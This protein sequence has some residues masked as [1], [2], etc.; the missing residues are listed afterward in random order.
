MAN[1]KQTTTKK[2]KRKK[3]IKQVAA[4]VVAAAG[5]A[6]TALVSAPNSTQVTDSTKHSTSTSVN[7]ED[8]TNPEPEAV[9]GAIDSTRDYAGDNYIDY[10][11]SDYKGDDSQDMSTPDNMEPENPT[12]NSEIEYTTEITY[13][14]VQSNEFSKTIILSVP[15]EL[16]IDVVDMMFKDTLVVSGVMPIENSFTSIPLIFD[17]FDNITFKLHRSG[18]IIG[19]AKFINEKLMTNVKAVK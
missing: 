4:G 1:S 18:E 7:N 14:F 2:E 16:S 5:I 17:N 8:V 12:D 6:C 19:D 9:G 11:L 15:D 10:T 3:R 13:E